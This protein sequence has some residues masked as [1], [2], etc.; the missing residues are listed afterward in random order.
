MVILVILL[1]IIKLCD[2]NGGIGFSPIINIW[3]ATS[4]C[5]F[6][7]LSG[8]SNCLHQGGGRQIDFLPTDG[9][10]DDLAAEVVWSEVYVEGF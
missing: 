8:D 5:C 7:S 10:V 2:E 4:F 6:A 1:L 3:R 9:D